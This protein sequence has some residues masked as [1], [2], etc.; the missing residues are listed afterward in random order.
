M[1]VDM[2]GPRYGTSPDRDFSAALRGLRD[3]CDEP[4]I[5]HAIRKR[6]ARREAVE[7]RDLLQEQGFTPR[8]AIGLVRFVDEEGARF[9]VPCVGS[10]L[11]TGQLEVAEIA[12]RVDDDGLSYAEAATKAGLDVEAAGRDEQVLRRLGAFVEVHVEQGF[13][14]AAEDVDSPLGVCGFIRPHGRWRVELRGRGD[15]AG[16]ARFPDRSDPMLE[17]A[18]LITGF[19][20]G[21]MAAG[22]AKAA[23]A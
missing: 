11:V 2:I 4:E 6:W 3:G 7:A 21:I 9:G 22:A 17:L 16:T 20:D 19:I 8:R 23:V 18:R 10:R 12:G 5:A 14:L 13:T 1:M 15:H